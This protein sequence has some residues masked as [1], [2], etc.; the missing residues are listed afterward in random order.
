MAETDNEDRAHPKWL[1]ADPDTADLGETVEAVVATIE[2]SGDDMDNG[3]TRYRLREW[4]REVWTER[5]KKVAH[6]DQ[7]EALLKEKGY[8]DSRRDL[9]LGLVPEDEEEDEI[10]TLWDIAEW[11]A[12]K[13]L[14]GDGY[15]DI[16]LRRLVC[17]CKPRDGCGGSCVGCCW[18][19]VVEDLYQATVADELGLTLDQAHLWREALR[20]HDDGCDAYVEATIILQIGN[21]SLRSN[22]TDA[23]ELRDE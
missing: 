22:L 19:E 20:K 18:R 9:R 15:L 11:A 14:E 13:P 21:L 12:T 3:P 4:A 10:E 5:A 1:F 6:Q 23:E 7:V 8:H 16:R 2:R 17:D